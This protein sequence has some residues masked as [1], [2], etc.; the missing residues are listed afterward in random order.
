MLTSGGITKTSRLAAFGLLALTPIAALAQGVLEIPSQGSAQTGIGVISGWHCTGRVID[1]VIDNDSPLTAGSGTERVDTAAVC[2]H[3]RTGF[4]L[5]LN[6]NRLG[7]GR[8]VVVVRSDGIEFARS[9]FR[10]VTLGAEFL[11]NKQ[12]F[13]HLPNF[14]EAGKT[15]LATWDEEKQNVSIVSVAPGPDNNF[16]DGETCAIS[17]AIT[18]GRPSLTDGYLVAF[19]A[20]STCKGLPAPTVAVN[21]QQFRLSGGGDLAPRFSAAAAR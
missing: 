11:T 14:P 17:G 9:E 16:L 4:S 20:K 5:L 15:A 8:H 12:G 3:S 10:I 2:G 1:V 21:G 18:D 19:F 13:F 7:D 6:Y